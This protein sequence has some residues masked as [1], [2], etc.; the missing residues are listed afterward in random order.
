[1]IDVTMLNAGSVA[2]LQPKTDAA[3]EWFEEHIG[4]DNGFQPYWPTVAV[5]ARFLGSVVQGLYR[6]GLKVSDA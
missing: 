1:M 2:L 6:D 5:E 4:R 3:R